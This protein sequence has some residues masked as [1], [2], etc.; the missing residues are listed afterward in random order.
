MVPVEKL[1]EL[2]FSLAIYPDLLLSSSMRAMTRALEL[3]KEGGDSSTVTQTFAKTK[4]MV[5]F[6]K[7]DEEESRYRLPE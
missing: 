6:D 2:G 3:L 4:S 1:R 5:G 7:Y